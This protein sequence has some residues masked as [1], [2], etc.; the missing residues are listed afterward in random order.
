MLLLATA[1]LMVLLLL[2][3]IFSLLLPELRNLLF[4]LLDLL[5]EVQDVALLIP[6]ELV[7]GWWPHVE[8]KE[9]A[10]FRVSREIAFWLQ[11]VDAIESVVTP[12]FSN[13]EL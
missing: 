11:L 12:A 9:D 2:L 7:V 5:L 10:V 6:R 1:L 8:F 4:L 13:F 3:G